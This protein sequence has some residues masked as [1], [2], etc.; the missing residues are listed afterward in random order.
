MLKVGLTGGIA[1]GKSTLGRIFAKLGARVIDAD[2]IAHDLQCP[3][4]PIWRQIVHSFGEDILRPD[5]TIDRGRLGQIIFSDS[6][7]RALLERIMHPAI[8]AKEEELMA[9][10]ERPGK[11]EVGMVEE[12]LLIEVGSFRRFDRIL[13][14]VAT[15]EV[16]LERLKGKG[17]SE[18]EALLRIRTQ[19]PL[20]LKIKYADYLIDNSGTLRDAKNRAR[21]LYPILLEEAK[22][23]KPTGT[24][25]SE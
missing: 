3:D 24:G 22:K 13:L 2:A 11:I 6:G 16:Q 20:S 14:V 7:K 25:R 21:E 18:E 9:E 19:M 10:W 17:L 12:A 5:R 15:E 8:I 4:H 1:T 23:L